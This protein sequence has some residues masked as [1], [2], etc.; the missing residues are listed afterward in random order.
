M[1]K[2]YWTNYRI[3][4]EDTD[5]GGVVYYA[6]YLKFFERARTELLRQVGIFQSDLIKESNLIFVVTNCEIA[7][8]K[9][10]KLDDLVCIKTIITKI[11]KA[12]IEMFQEMFLGEEL[13]NILEVKIASVD[14]V[15]KKPKKIPN[16]I[17]NKI[18]V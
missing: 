2:E 14:S 17:I 7:F 12:S 9:V 18:H 6:N 5:A 3:Y 13:L 15:T 16:S 8:K 11:G 10:A 1:N 4:Y